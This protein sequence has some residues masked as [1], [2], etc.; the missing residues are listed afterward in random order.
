MCVHMD[1]IIE[2][3]STLQGLDT[4]GV[5]VY[6]QED[7][8]ANMF[9]EDIPEP[10]LSPERALENAPAHGPDGFEVPAIHD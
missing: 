8:G 6:G 2:A 9:R 4:E 5:P 1:K 7:T 3:V 10:S